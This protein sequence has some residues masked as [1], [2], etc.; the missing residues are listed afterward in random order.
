MEETVHT[1]EGVLRVLCMPG[2]GDCLFASLGH[3]IWGSPPNTEDIKFRIRTLRAIAVDFFKEHLTQWTDRLHA[4]AVV[5]FTE[6]GWSSMCA[7]TPANQLVQHY[8]QCLKQPGFWGGEEA[9]LAVASVFDFR[10]EIFREHSSAHVMNARGR[11]TL[12]IV[13]RLSSRGNYTHY[14]SVL[15]IASG[16]R[17]REPEQSYGPPSKRLAVDAAQITTNPRK[18]GETTSEYNLS[19]RPPDPLPQPHAQHIQQQHYVDSYEVSQHSDCSQQEPAALNIPADIFIAGTWNVS[20]CSLSSD[21]D[22]IDQF[23]HTNNVAVACLQE[24]RLATCAA[25]TNTYAWY[26]VNRQRETTPRMGGGTAILVHRGQ[27][28]TECNFFRVS[29]NICGAKITVFGEQLIIFSI[30]ARSISGQAD[31]EI[32]T[33]INYLTSLSARQRNNTII[34]GDFNAHIGYEDLL[35]EENARVGSLLFHPS[36]NPN[37][38]A[39]KELLQFHRYR[40]CSSFGPDKNVL[41][42]WQRG[43]RRAQIDHIVM[44]IIQRFRKP[45]C[46]CVN[47]NSGFSDHRLLTL[48]VKHR[49]DK[50]GQPPSE[51]TATATQKPKHPNIHVGLLTTDPLAKTR[52]HQKLSENLQSQPEVNADSEPAHVMERINTAILEAAKATLS[53]PRSPNTPKRKQAGRR[54]EKARMELLADRQNPTKKRLCKEARIKKELAYQEHQEKKVR[55]FFETLENYTPLD[56]VRLTYRYLRQHRRRVNKKKP[57]YIPI[58]AWEEKLRSGSSEQEIA[59]LPEPETPPSDSGPTLQD[60][61]RIVKMLRNNTAAGT[62]GIRPELIRYGSEALLQE[63][64]RLLRKI[65]ESNQVPQEMVETLQIPIPKVTRPTGPDEYRRITLCQTLYKVYSR[66]LLEQIEL[67]LGEVPNYQYAYHHNRSAEDQIF[68]VRQIL[69]ERWKKGRT[70]YIVSLDIRQAFD[71]VNLEKLPQLLL[72]RGVPAY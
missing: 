8:L 66:F 24:T 22:H 55:A 51:V 7:N 72:A 31:P 47:D 58:R 62:N 29:D 25:S 37:G 19:P 45:D 9:L 35:P 61:E 32:G 49:A 14:D 11:K 65:W 36:T 3:Q 60:V 40:L 50:D 70:T 59:W 46:K 63:I 34:L 54:Y 42:T 57:H 53:M 26:N 21:R 52:Y 1:D 44:P 56:R 41:C 68:I 13:H 4:Q 30:Y 43:N 71:T 16:R 64:H 17:S 18:E 28:G 12:K 15:S 33:L 67:F 69:D 10:I 23:L 5:A 27:F 38:E 20:G 6:C 2:D 39:L 48:R